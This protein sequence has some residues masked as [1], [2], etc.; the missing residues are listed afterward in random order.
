MSTATILPLSIIRN[1]VRLLTAADVA[2]LP[3]TL[4]SGDVDYELH[5]GKLIVM[6]P[7]G[8]IHARRQARFLRYLVTEGEERGHGEARGDVG[9]LLRRNP[10]HL[11][12]SDAAFIAASSCPPRV[13]SEGYLLTIPEL[14]VEVRSKNDT[15]LEIDEKVQDYLTAGVLLVW[16]ADPATRTVTTF[17]VN[18]PPVVSAAGDT[19][20]ADPVIPGFAVPVAELLPA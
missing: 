15:Q 16:I 6:P 7:P 13:S 1:G 20:T 19:L 18:R 8:D 3:R 17:Q 4:P 2:A 14:V 5:D 12:G 9:V 10:D 11:V